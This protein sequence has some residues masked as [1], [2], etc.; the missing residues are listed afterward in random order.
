MPKIDFDKI[1]NI[2]LPQFPSLIQAWLPNGNINGNEY[3]TLNPT[4]TDAEK[5]SFSI[6]VKSGVWSDFA[7]GEAGKD[8]IALYAYLN[9][10][11]MYEAAQTVTAMSG[12]K[13]DNLPNTTYNKKEEWTQI[14]PVPQEAI[15]APNHFPTKT[16]DGKWTKNDFQFKWEYFDRQN[17]LLGYIGRYT[18]SGNKKQIIPLTY[19]KNKNN[20]CKWKYKQFDIPRPLMNLNILAHTPSKPVILVE[21]E[22]CVEM[23]QEIIKKNAVVM[24]WPGGSK[25]IDKVDWTALKECNVMLWP[26]ADRAGKDAMNTIAGKLQTIATAIKIIDIPKDKPKGWDCADAIEDGW[27]AKDIFEFI[28]NHSKEYETR[29]IEY[30]SQPPEE[31]IN[32]NEPSE[33]LVYNDKPFQILGYSNNT[34][35]YLP[36]GSLQVIA[37]NLPQHNSAHLLGLAPLSYWEKTYY[38]KKGPDW[39][40]AANELI[41]TCHA[42]GVY[43][44]KLIRGAGA[45]YD[46]Q[47]VVLHLG[48]HLL[49]DQK[50][51]SISEIESRYIYEAGPPAEYLNMDPF[52]NKEANKLQQICDSLQWEKSIFGK[53]LAGWCAIAPICGA[54]DWRPHIWITGG[55]GTG[56][57]YT[58]KNVVKPI[59]GH[60]ALHAQ[61]ATTEAGLRQSMGTD[62]WP[63]IF[64]EIEAENKEGQR[65][66]EVILELMRQASSDTGARILKGSTSGKAL[67]YEIRSCFCLASIGVNI[68]Q[69]ADVS[70]ITV[71]SL[72]QDQ[73][74]SPS[75][76]AEKFNDLNKLL[77]K[78]LSDEYCAALRSRSILLIPIIRKNAKVFS[79]A[80]AIHLGNQRIGDQIGVLLAGAFSLTSQKEIDFDTAM[81]WIKNQEWDE[82]TPDDI[83]TDERCC[84]TYILES[85]MKIS[86]HERSIGE[87][88]ISQN[89]FSDDNSDFFPGENKSSGLKL[90]DIKKGLARHGIKLQDKKVIISDSHSA[91]KRIM[92]GTS[93]PKNWGR[94]LRRIN[95]AEIMKSTRFNGISTRATVLEWDSIFKE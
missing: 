89:D 29:E 20:E 28:K 65:R 18:D 41:N 95:N 68:G 59:L 66:V 40:Q 84:L 80:V 22:K 11:T 88:L 15:T 33:A 45:W 12:H 32:Y 82:H 35:Y 58:M 90:D 30:D 7:T 39:M 31:P 10:V 46:R 26:D 60:A 47:R 64:D 24:C 52:S 21:G 23:L 17:N 92:S 77:S 36:D 49:V 56:K 13:I 74:L 86:Y 78:T 87:L 2:I 71:L 75:E 55:S 1:N 42:K 6:N 34:Y 16:K 14:T 19:R 63:I 51:M 72:R 79:K 57:T 91:L 54:L 8:P 61:S 69:Y 85:T 81:A 5:G 94:I 83:D 4:R 3:V 70:R 44:P 25:A 43:N 67:S 73:Q 76:R 37:L 48:D 62:A 93:W 38:G 9:G 53:Y 27:N 50:K